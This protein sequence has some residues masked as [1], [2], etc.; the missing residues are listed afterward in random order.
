VLAIWANRALA[1]VAPLLITPIVTHHFGLEI[2]GIWLLA[3]LMASHLM[4]LDVGFSSSLVRFLA[5]H[6][7]LQDAEQASRFLSTAFV[8]LLVAGVA[9]FLLSPALAPAFLRVFAISPS[10]AHEAKL[11]A[12][13][14]IAYVGTS[15]PLRIGYALLSSCHRFDRIQ[16]WEAVGIALRLT[17]VLIVFKTGD[18]DVVDLGFIVFGCS[19]LSVAAI[20]LDGRMLN[21]QWPI[22]FSGF[23]RKSLRS[24]LSMG[25]A[26]LV[27]TVAWV[28]LSQGPSVLAGL[29]EGTRS[30]ALIAYPLMIFTSLTPFFSS[31]FALI[32]APVAAGMAALNQDRKLLS[33]TVTAARYLTSAATALFLAFLLYGTDLL[34][35][36]LAG[37]KLS[38]ADLVT[39]SRGLNIIL[40]GFALSGLAGMGRSILPAVGRHWPF[41]MSELLSTIAGLALAAVLVGI[42]TVGVLGVAAGVALSLALRG[43]VW[44]PVMLAR[45]FSV[46]AVAIAFHSNGMPFLVAVVTGTAAFGARWL[47]QS[48][49]P[50]WNMW[51][52]NA[53]VAICAALVWVP[54]TWLFVIEAGHRT[55][56]ASR[57]CGR[58]GEV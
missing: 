2:T 30:V 22:R 48:M 53:I 51:I 45:H 56:L 41:A 37:P 58:R 40:F 14:T 29:S 11:L 47:L 27:V 9:L 49:L 50:G 54:L 33:M 10:Y 39:M 46:S 52:C 38:T 23:E 7:A 17:L 43:L 26:A 42:E 8:A 18:P 5:R 57:M 1:I 31:T 6:R 24:L 12:F 20:F 35:L 3:T 34:T 15:L 55:E 32:M 13:V 44:N 36:W 16:F 28:L 25:G 21:P 19:F 4:L